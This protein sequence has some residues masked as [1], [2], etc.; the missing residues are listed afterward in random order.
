MQNRLV[1]SQAVFLLFMMSLNRKGPSWAGEMGCWSI[2]PD[3]R[4]NV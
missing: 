1:V 3:G 2:C 4:L